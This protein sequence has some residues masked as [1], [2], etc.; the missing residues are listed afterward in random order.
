MHLT[1]ERLEAPG[2]GEVGGGWD[3]L[4]EMGGVWDVEQRVDWEGDK[5]WTVKKRLMNSKKRKGMKSIFRFFSWYFN[6]LFKLNEI[7]SNNCWYTFSFIPI[8]G[9]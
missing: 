6:F 3:I 2:S 1:L 7:F 8:S 4:L 9:V 5:E